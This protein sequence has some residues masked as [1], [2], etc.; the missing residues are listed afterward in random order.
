MN[1]RIAIV[2]LFIPLMILTLLQL[3]FAV[4]QWILTGN[5]PRSIFETS[6]D[7]IYEGK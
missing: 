6:I 5:I 4:I 1:K 2:I 3:P 7:D